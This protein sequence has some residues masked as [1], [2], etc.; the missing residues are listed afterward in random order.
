MPWARVNQNILLCGFDIFAK[1][2]LRL[3]HKGDRLHPSV[4]K[5]FNFLQMPVEGLE[6]ASFLKAQFR[7]LDRRRRR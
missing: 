5:P 6:T 1:G 3:Y 7:F 2:S 4:W